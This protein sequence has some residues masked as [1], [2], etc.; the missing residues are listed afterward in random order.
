LPFLIEALH[1]GDAVVRNQA[2]TSLGSLKMPAAIGALLDIARR[3]PDIPASLLSE[4]LSECSVE[5]LGFLDAPAAEPGMDSTIHPLGEPVDLNSFHSYQELSDGVDDAELDEVLGR[6]ESS[7]VQVRTGAANE[8]ALFTVQRSVGALTSL[9]VNDPD[10]TVRSVAV[11]SLGAI[12]HETVFAGVLL[13]L[14][15]ESRVVRA[16]AARTMTGLHLDRG[17][18]YARIMETADPE[19]LQK[20]AQACSQTGI[21]KQAVDRLASE[22]RRQAFEAFSIFSLLARGGESDLILDTIRNHHDEEVR[23]CAV[24]VL[25]VAGQPSMVDKVR[26]IVGH[27][28]I[29]ENVRTALLEVLYKLDQEG[30]L[31][32]LTPSDN[33]AMTLHNS[34]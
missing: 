17:E 4:T 28:S 8:L 24:R 23:L 2:I 14:A 27:Q 26:D 15:D 7:D 6:L 3:H 13:A 9:L 25:S 18:A 16:A 33:E 32:E 19:M 1:D 29:P 10:E 22:D 5:S 30:S 20:V 12:D 34:P 11:A 21:A 31:P